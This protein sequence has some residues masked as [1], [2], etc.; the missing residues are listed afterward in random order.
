MCWRS[1]RAGPTTS[2][3]PCPTPD[4]RSSASP[5]SR[6][7]GP[8]EP[9]AAGQRGEPSRYLSEAAGWRPPPTSARY[10]SGPTPRQSRAARPP[11]LPHPEP[12]RQHHQLLL[13]ELGLLG[14]P[15]Q[16]QGL[17]RLHLL[18]EEQHLH[19][20]QRLSRG[21]PQPLRLHVQDRRRHPVVHGH[22]LRRVLAVP[23][24][25]P[26]RREALR[27]A[28]LSPPELAGDVAGAPRRVMPSQR[29]PPRGQRS[30]HPGASGAPCS[31]SIQAR[32]ACRSASI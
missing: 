32:A 13:V 2:P 6:A 17:L 12:R 5:W 4:R 19:H 29:A 28:R 30:L 9:L 8:T 14:P 27:V 3:W 31:S 25:L 26:D 16:P 18:R 21:H 24:R 20:Q 11:G 22:H 15:E 1:A 7:E 23:G 10:A